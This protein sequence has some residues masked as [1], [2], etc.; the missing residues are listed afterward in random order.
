MPRVE[1]FYAAKTNP[2]AKICKIAH[3]MGTGFDVASNEEI[4]N[5]LSLGAKPDDL[6]LANPLKSE[7]QILEARR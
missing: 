6:I 3:Q 2:D 7:S 4:Q 5:V 1:I